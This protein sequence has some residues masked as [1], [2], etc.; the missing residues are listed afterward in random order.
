MLI[1]WF[2]RDSM[3]GCCF[4]GEELVYG[5]YNGGFEDWILFYD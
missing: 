1:I 2:S 5:F 3:V 4:L